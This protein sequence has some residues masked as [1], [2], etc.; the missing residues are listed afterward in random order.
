MR[1]RLTTITLLLIAAVAGL[2]CE[3]DTKLTIT[4]GNPPQFHM[5]GS[6]LLGRIVVRGPKTLRRIDGPD[7]SAYWYIEPK[8]GESMR[9]VER[10]SP[11]T[12][13][14]APE[15]YVQ[16]YPEK[17]E[18]QPLLENETYYIQVSTTNAN[19]TFKH[20]V[21]RKG[22]VVFADYEYELNEN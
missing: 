12:Y 1:N 5:T 9:N 6:G 19:G 4:G 16:V 14:K 3:I 8:D 2:S 20:F 17:G 11:I 10:L 21:I 7:S 13:G 15:G 18:A 22:K